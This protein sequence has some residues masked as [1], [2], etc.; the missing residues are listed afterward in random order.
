MGLV[1]L[2][3]K[4]T[5]ENWGFPWHILL[6]LCGQFLATVLLRS[7]FNLQA[8]MSVV[9]AAVIVFV[10]GLLYEI[11]QRSRDNETP[12]GMRQDLIA[13]VSGILTGIILLAVSGYF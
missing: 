7:A 12:T 8:S 9:L 3:G 4:I 5:R 2:L 11:A 10:I 13:D 6:A 1:D